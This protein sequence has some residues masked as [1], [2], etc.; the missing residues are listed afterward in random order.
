MLPGIKDIS[1]FSKKKTFK[2]WKPRKGRQDSWV[3]LGDDTS[4]ESRGLGSKP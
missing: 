3:L 2:N 4:R 1:P